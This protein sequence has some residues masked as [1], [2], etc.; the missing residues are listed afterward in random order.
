MISNKLAPL[1]QRRLI[2]A[3]IAKLMQS[4]K[5]KNKACVSMIFPLQRRNKYRRFI[6]LS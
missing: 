3:F 5:V 4:I 6:I 2:T 1:R